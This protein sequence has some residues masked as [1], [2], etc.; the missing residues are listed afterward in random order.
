MTAAPL[1]DGT[2]PCAGEDLTLFFPSVGGR[3]GQKLVDQAKAICAR[4][5]FTAACREYAIT[6]QAVSGRF[7][8]GVWGGT[9]ERERH[10]LRRGRQAAA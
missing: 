1:F 8:A 10:H 3:G 2:Q 6:T 7:L 9:T 4:C 5:P